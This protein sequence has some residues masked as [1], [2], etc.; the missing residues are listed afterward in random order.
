M[1][2]FF[3]FFFSQPHFFRKK[4]CRAIAKSNPLQALDGEQLR[5]SLTT[6]AEAAVAEAYSQWPHAE[7]TVLAITSWVP[8]GKSF[9]REFRTTKVL[10][11]SHGHGVAFLLSHA[12]LDPSRNNTTLSIFNNH[13]FAAAI[14]QNVV[15]V[16]RAGPTLENGIP[17]FNCKADGA[18]EL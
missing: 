13:S 17:V 18:T 14:G 1:A 12:P 16:A 5:K 8:A 11:H 6:T 7:G 15:V 9:D 3:F 4:K 2:R 10:L